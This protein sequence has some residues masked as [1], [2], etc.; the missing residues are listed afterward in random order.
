MLT[1]GRRDPCAAANE[2]RQLNA[3]YLLKFGYDLD[4]AAAQSNDTHSLVFEVVVLIPACRM[5]DLALEVPKPI[6]I[7]PLLVIEQATSTDE[8]VTGVFYYAS[9][10]LLDMDVPF[11]PMLIPSA[12]GDLV[13]KLGETLNAV[14]TR[15]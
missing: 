15:G 7:R 5:H 13:L 14:F 1:Q 2:A 9:I 11:A 3:G 6:N 8:H 10:W 4:G 12:I